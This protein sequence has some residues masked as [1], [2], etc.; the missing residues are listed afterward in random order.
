VTADGRALVGYTVESGCALAHG[1]PAGP[2]DG[3]VSAIDEFGA[4]CHARGWC[5]AY[6]RVTPALLPAFRA[7]R[8]R[9][10]FIGQDAV[11][12]TA[13]F[14][15]ETSRKEAFKRYL[16]KLD[17]ESW[18]V[19]R[20]RP[21][22]DVTLVD[23][24]EQVSREWLAHGRRERAFTIGRFDRAYVQ[25][26]EM[27]ALRDPSGRPRAFLTLVPSFLPERVAVDLMRRADDAPAGAMEALFARAIE[28]LHADGVRWLSLGLAPMRGATGL[29]GLWGRRRFG[30][31]AAFK[32]K[33][34]PAWEDRWLVYDG[35]PLA[36]VKKGY[37]LLRAN[38]REAL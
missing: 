29:P 10:F 20:E 16:R 25:A 7:R 15:S 13:T 9:A 14:V 23:A 28:A 24:L 37:A 12:D 35:R 18:R 3:V 38:E 19:T 26:S 17:K 1:E 2:D 30:G 33:F 6:Y 36:V 22:N 5:V 34:A 27:F 8:Y 32:E 31:L 4:H 21:P 11:V